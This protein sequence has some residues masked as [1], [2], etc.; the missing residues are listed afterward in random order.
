MR[1]L[2][3]KIIACDL[4]ES[5]TKQDVLACVLPASLIRKE[6]FKKVTKETP[7]NR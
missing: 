3:L 7:I 6:L 2:P 1:T 5:S 4:L